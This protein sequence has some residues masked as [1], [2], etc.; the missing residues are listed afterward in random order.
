[1]PPSPA[2]Q[3]S[4]PGPPPTRHADTRSPTRSERPPPR[5]HPRPPQR[6]A[7]TATPH[8]LRPHGR[9][10]TRRTSPGHLLDAIPAEPER[11]RLVVV[12]RRTAGLDSSGD[13]RRLV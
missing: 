9:A 5:G 12:R 1:T 6:H 4:P 7:A 13:H 2:T 3:R 8:P 11:V 10:A